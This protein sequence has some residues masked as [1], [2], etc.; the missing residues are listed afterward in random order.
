[1]NTPQP[2][3]KQQLITSRNCLKQPFQLSRGAQNSQTK[4]QIELDEMMGETM[5]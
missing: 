4:L 1:M 2:G 5:E 3:K